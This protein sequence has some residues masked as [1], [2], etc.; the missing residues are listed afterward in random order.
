MK[1]LNSI[2]LAF[3]VLF[4]SVLLFG[5]SVYQYELSNTSDD[6]T[7]KEVVIAPGG[8]DSIATT[9]KKEH[10]IRNK[11]I[12]KFYVHLTGKTNLKAAAYSLSENMGVKKIV[13]ILYMGSGKNTNPVRITF[14]E[15]LNMRSITA[16]ITENTNHTEEE[17]YEKLQDQTYLNNLIDKYWFISNEILQF[18]IYYSLEGYLYPSTYDFSSKKVTIEEIFNTMLEETKKQLTPYQTKLQESNL[19]IHQILTLASIVELEG[20]TLEDRKG[21]AGVFYNRLDKNMTLGSDVTTYY[22]AKV[23]M[24][25]RDLYKSEVSECNNYNTRCP[26]Y[27]KLPI[28]PICNPSIDAIVAVLE[29]TKSDN[30]YFVADKNKKVYFN[31]NITEHNDTIKKLKEEGLWYE[32]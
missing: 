30:Y 18:G 16:M 32:Y 3:L 6:D 29:P 10:L 17:V 26:T 22:G 7:L 14:K 15:G 31:K 5:Y 13:D 9:L 19:S 25:E 23:N 20:I 28:S 1:I 21:I 24:G 2:K 8:I 27:I 12:F 4:F 11:L